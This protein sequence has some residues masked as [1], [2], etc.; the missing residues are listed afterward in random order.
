MA[1]PGPRKT[2]TATLKLR[3]T[4][5]EDRRPTTEP[6]PIDHRPTKP[7]GI[8]PESE[9]VWDEVCTDLQKLGLLSS[10]D[11]KILYRYCRLFPRWVRAQDFI[12]RH[13]E[14][15][16]VYE[17]DSRGNFVLDGQGNRQIKYVAQLPQAATVNKLGVMLLRI[18]QEIGLTA[19]ARA[20][21]SVLPAVV[22]SAAR[23]SDGEDFILRR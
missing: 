13:G 23:T 14:S 6:R 5:R 12:E 15:Y 16:P 3:G 22:E 7:T 19:S 9:A 18:E 21:L 4:Y 2:P 8:T 10:T 1:K 20:G 17:R 11:G